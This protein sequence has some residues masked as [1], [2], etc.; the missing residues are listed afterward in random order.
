MEQTPA[1]IG[2]LVKE[3]LFNDNEFDD[4]QEKLNQTLTQERIK[5][6]NPS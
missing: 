6:E 2:T 3:Q 4:F 5:N 1:Q